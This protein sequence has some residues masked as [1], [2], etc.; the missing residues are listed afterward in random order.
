MIAIAHER[1]G[2]S[3]V[4]AVVL[5]ICMLMILCIRAAAL[6]VEH[7]SVWSNDIRVDSPCK[8]CQIGIDLVALRALPQ[9][10]Y[11]SRHLP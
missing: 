6:L 5:M 8:L 2:G 7:D 3:I 10:V 1:K 9:C 11:H 4:P